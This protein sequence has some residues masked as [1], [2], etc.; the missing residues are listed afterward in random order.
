MARPVEDQAQRHQLVFP[1]VENTRSVWQYAGRVGAEVLAAVGRGRAAALR[2]WPVPGAL[3]PRDR[4]L[5][6]AEQMAGLFPER[7]L[8]RGSTVVV[9][10]SRP[11]ATSVA[12]SLLSPSAAGYWC[13]VVG[14]PDLGLVAAAQLGGELSR[15]ALVPV[16]G[17]RWPVVTAA[18][19]E[20]MD[21]V[22]VRPAGPV[23]PTDA[24]KLEARARERGA[25]LAVLSDAW[26]GA[27]DVRLDVGEGSWH[28]A[29]SGAGFLV[30]RELEVVSTGRGAASRPRRAR[31][32]FASS[33]SRVV[34]LADGAASSAPSFRAAGSGPR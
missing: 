26:P 2:D 24:R 34:S 15:L 16:P 25:V 30:G 5:P 17:E 7:A 14:A 9:G 18:L 6:V 3:L 22:L 29:Q 1:A 31:L 4:S 12:L 19:L 33:T 28:G 23:R 20:G 13:G 11:G 32:T 8:R 10:R 27:A 21:V